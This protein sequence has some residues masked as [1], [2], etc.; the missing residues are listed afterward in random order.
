M[1]VDATDDDRPA[2]T[3]APA[4]AHQPLRADVSLLGTILGETIRLQAGDSVFHCV[5][6]IRE[7]GR[8][9]REQG[10]YTPLQTLVQSLDA[11]Q[12]VD[13][14]RSFSHFLNYANI[15]EQHHRVRRRR[16]YQR[17]PETAIEPGSLTELLPRLLHQGI[18]AAAIIDVIGRMNIELVLT[19]HPTE[20]TRRTLRHKYSDIAHI[21]GLL[22]RGDLT[23]EERQAQLARLRRR[24]IAAWHS[25]EIRHT[26]PTPQNEAKWGFTTVERTL[27]QAVPALLRKLDRQLQL[28]L[29]RPLPADATPIRFA[30]WMGGDRD[31]NPFV[32]ADVTREVLLLA[33]WKAADLLIGDITALREDLSMRDANPALRAIV[34]QHPEP[35][36]ELLRQV[37]RRLVATRDWA[38]ARLDRGSDDDDALAVAAIYFEDRQLLEPL[39]LIQQSLIECQMRDIADGSLIDIIRRVRCFGMTLLRLD[40]RQEAQRHTDAVTAVA[41]HLGG[42][43]YPALDEAGRQHFLLQQLAEA[44]RLP[45]RPHDFAPEVSEVLATF[46]LLAAQPSS[47]LGAYIISM[48]RQPS[49]VLSVRWLQHL[50]GDPHPQR[51]VPLFETLDDL[52]HAGA[53]LRALFAVEWYRGDTG[54][55]QEVMI[56]YSDSAKD[57]GF[58]TAAWAQYQAIEDIVAACAEHDVELTL[59]H[60]RGGSASRG[61]GPLHPA[62]LALPQGAMPGRVRITEQGEVIDFKFGQPGIA[63]RNLEL[64]TTATLESA[65]LPAQPVETEWRVLLD[66]LSETALQAYRKVIHDDERVAEYYR[67]VTP[68][69]ELGLLELGS[70]PASRKPDG[71]IKSLRAIP[72]VFAWTQIR[73]MLP[74]WYGAGLSMLSAMAEGRGEAVRD[75][76]ER[77]RF[78]RML[79]DM[80]EMVLAKA[81]DGIAA[82]Y[83]RSLTDDEHLLR[84]GAH[85]REQL[86]QTIHAVED[87]NQRALLADKPVLRRSID[88]RNPYVYPLHMIQIE[89]I[90]RLRGGAEDPDGRLKQALKIAITGIAAGLR[91]TG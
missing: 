7:L 36:R 6:K 43:D 56:G 81:D 14:A 50:C 25:D 17:N 5:E 65:L 11:G 1:T 44:R 57:A 69:P 34:N 3:A 85:F 42:E 35:Y 63:R 61:G 75:M 13:V 12:L 60:G 70:R 73:L 26:R 47:A 8:V 45:D 10:D 29:E 28:H 38:E 77:W 40:I 30:S 23:P 27:W 58:L 86:Q 66:R 52:R 53:T 37:R 84:L 51:I 31:G 91:N 72:W 19:A 21:L 82:H 49:D 89:A 24:I 9:G 33:R 22:D 39:L 88:V 16:Q 68:G 32:T 64:Y 67:Q 54:R 76:A 48:A 15:A 90:R 2:A 46:R 20:V 78:F 87:I 41:K 83:E 59:F 80:Q 62:L 55:R 79:L 71:G 18:G 4:D 74:A